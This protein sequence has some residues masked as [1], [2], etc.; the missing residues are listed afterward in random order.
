MDALDL[1]RTTTSLLERLFDQADD[2]IWTIFHERYAAVLLSVAR[3][4]G[5][6]EADARDAGQETLLTFVRDYRAAKYDRSK[7]RLGAWLVGI[8]KHRVQSLRRERQHIVGE[9]RQGEPT[10]EFELERVWEEELR[11]KIVRDAFFLLERTSGFQPDTVHAFRLV[12]LEGKRAPDAAEE[13]GL[14]T[15]AVYLA[16]HKCAERLRT[17]ARELEQAYEAL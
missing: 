7:G 12:A 2:E 14:T 8:L 4:M 3:R 6:D 17:F 9:S 11:A 1:S 13:L 5:L 16:R 15:Q 10:T